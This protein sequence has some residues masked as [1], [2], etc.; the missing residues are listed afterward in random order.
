MN[1]L[2]VHLTCS[3]SIHSLPTIISLQSYKICTCSPCL[4]RSHGTIQIG[5]KSDS[6]MTNFGQLGRGLIVSSPNMHRP[7]ANQRSNMSP[8]SAGPF[9][10]SR[11]LVASF[12]FNL[13]IISVIFSSPLPFDRSVRLIPCFT[14]ICRLYWCLMSYFIYTVSNM[15]LMHVRLPR[16]VKFG[17]WRGGNR[18]VKSIV[19]TFVPLLLGLSHH[20]LPM[21]TWDRCGIHIVSI[22][23]SGYKCRLWNFWP[24][25]LRL[26]L[27][28]RVFTAI[29][30]LYLIPFV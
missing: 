4:D 14:F 16:T 9:H 13:D 3:D 21:V 2:F 29:S 27:I 26:S 22:I 5:C 8:I 11:C 30:L 28:V 23:V 18:F 12:F 10:P 20:S 24:Y 15:N 25:E 19:V 6:S 7:K 17:T 1:I